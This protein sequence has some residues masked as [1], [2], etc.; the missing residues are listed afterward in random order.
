MVDLR[1]LVVAED[2]LARAGLATIL[3]DQ[4][5]CEV[6]G[7]SGVGES[8]LAN[9]EAFQPDAIIWD[10]GWDNE[11]SLSSLEDLVAGEREAGPAIIAL[12]S[13]QGGA[14]AAW[15]AGARALLLRDVTGEQLR[16]A[17]EAVANGLVVIDPLFAG[18]L[19]SAGSPDEPAPVQ[20]LT[21]REL[22]VLNLLAE[23]LANKN[24]AQ[25]LAISE[26]TVKF[27]VNAIMGKLGAQ[28]RT[29]AVVRATRLGLISL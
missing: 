10:L 27:H 28:S 6:V 7:Q 1:L 8:V 21:P 29:E 12:L 20:E 5:G 23:G 2:P 9:L 24:I 22:Q 15:S 19:L 17:A 25:N 13:D 18:S 3:A 4:P 11:G 14:A 26:H 16:A